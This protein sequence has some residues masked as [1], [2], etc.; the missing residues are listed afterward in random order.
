VLAAAKVSA[1]NIAQE[2]RGRIARRKS[3]PTRSRHT[4]DTIR[5]IPATVGIGYLVGAES[6]DMP[7]LPHWLEKGTVKM[8]ARPALVPA[9]ELESG[10]HLLRI[11]EAIQSAIDAKGLGE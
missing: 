7:N 10:V 4:G 8:T 11:S 2:Y 5:V 6:P 1:E 9:A 3:G